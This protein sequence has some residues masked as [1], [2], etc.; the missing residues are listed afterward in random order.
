[1]RGRGAVCAGGGVDEEACSGILG[2]T[3]ELLSGGQGAVLVHLTCKMLPGTRLR[4]ALNLIRTVQAVLR[5][6]VVWRENGVKPGRTAVASTMTS[7]RP[8]RPEGTDW[9]S[10]QTQMQSSEGGGRQ[11]SPG[12]TPQPPGTAGRGQQF[13]FAEDDAGAEWGMGHPRV[14]GQERSALGLG[15]RTPP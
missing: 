6:A 10:G 4:I 15:S 5:R 11:V 3:R 14:T 8:R 12:P 13:C 7:E 2:W 9:G 1:M